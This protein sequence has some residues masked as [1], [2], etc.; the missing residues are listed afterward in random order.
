MP[1]CDKEE[2]AISWDTIN[3]HGQNYSSSSYVG[4]GPRKVEQETTEVYVDITIVA[5]GERGA[6]HCTRNTRESLTNTVLAKTPH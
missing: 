1:S 3:N 6:T 2:Q 4:A 5:S